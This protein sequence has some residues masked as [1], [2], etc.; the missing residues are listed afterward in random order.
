MPGGRG[1]IRGKWAAS[2]W[3]RILVVR[4]GKTA[5]GVRRNYMGKGKKTKEQEERNET[6]IY[7]NQIR[8]LGRNQKFILA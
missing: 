4:A 7:A 5:D 6:S 8:F 2:V 3:G 1:G